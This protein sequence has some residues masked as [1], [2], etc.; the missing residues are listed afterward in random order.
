MNEHERERKAQCVFVCVPINRRQLY[1]CVPIERCSSAMQI[2]HLNRI[3]WLNSILKRIH[4]YRKEKNNSNRKRFAIIFL[5]FLLAF[6]IRFF[7]SC[8]CL[9]LDKPPIKW[10][11]TF[12]CD[13]NAIPM[14][15]RG[16]ENERMI[17][18]KLTYFAWWLIEFFSILYALSL[19]ALPTSTHIHTHP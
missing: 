11:K 5:P 2:T 4:R 17:L 16:K 7:L 9:I 3:L 6:T 12:T 1:L 13:L 10:C 15:N 8:S 18:I 19:L 14:K